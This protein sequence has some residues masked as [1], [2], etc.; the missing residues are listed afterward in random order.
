MLEYAVNMLSN[1]RLELLKKIE[2]NANI[3]VNKAELSKV[4]YELGYIK[5]IES[6]VDT[7]ERIAEK[8]LKRMEEEDV[9]VNSADWSKRDNR[10]RRI[11]SQIKL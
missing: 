2:K 4:E 3:L 6:S 9:N 10:K 8:M 11:Y 7:I 1:R 5:Q